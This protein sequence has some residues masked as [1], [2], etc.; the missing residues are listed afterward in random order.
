MPCRWEESARTRRHA[1]RRAET[2]TGA[3]VRIMRGH[4]ATHVLRTIR[5]SW[6]W[7][8]LDP[9]AVTATNAFGNVI[10]RA[11]DG[12]YWRVCPEELSC[13]V[14]A[15][16]DATFRALW[17]SEEFQVDWQ[18]TQLVEIVQTLLGPVSE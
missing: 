8:G 12:A 9:A 6:G 13:E 10:V 5:E 1:R 18:M 11:T 3:R 17:A 2:L 16:D 4:A 14:V 7:T 15:R